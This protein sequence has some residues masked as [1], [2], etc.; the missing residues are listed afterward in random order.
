MRVA[1]EICVKCPGRR[2][3]RSVCWPSTSAPGHPLPSP[4]FGGRRVRAGLGLRAGL[5]A[6]ALPAM[7]IAGHS[8]IEMTMNVDGHVTLDEKR[9]A[10]DRLG[11]LFEED[12]K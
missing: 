2:R 7:D 9:E 11:G 4:S 8:T 3:T 5:A 1:V 12:D 6:L 10:L